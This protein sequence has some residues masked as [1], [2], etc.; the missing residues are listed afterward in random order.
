MGATLSGVLIAGV[1]QMNGFGL[2]IGWHKGDLSRVFASVP[3][4]L[5]AILGW[6]MTAVAASL[7]APF[8][9]DTLNKI[10]TIRAGG[11]APAEK[12][13]G[14]NGSEEKKKEAGKKC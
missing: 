7:G 5:T 3:S 13:P 12:N 14:E 8:W 1:S 6:L 9:F 4:F 10:V 11:R 2:P